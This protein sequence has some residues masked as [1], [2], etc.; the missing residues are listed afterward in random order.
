MPDYKRF[1]VCL[2]VDESKGITKVQT[3][4]TPRRPG[5]TMSKTDTTEKGLESLIM[6]HLT[7]MDGLACGA[8]GVSTSE[9]LE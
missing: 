1:R 8:A 5:Q 4:P 6:R 7:G 9:A 3:K 2:I